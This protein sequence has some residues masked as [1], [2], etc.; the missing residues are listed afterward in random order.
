MSRTLRTI[1]IRFGNLFRNETI[2]HLNELIKC[3]NGMYL[4]DD[5]GSILKHFDNEIKHS[6]VL[7]K[8]AS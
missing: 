8:P 7:N 1:R 2:S 5:E 4:F 3:Q 6:S